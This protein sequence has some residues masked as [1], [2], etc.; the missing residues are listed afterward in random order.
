MEVFKGEELEEKLK[1]LK[2]WKLN[3]SSGEIFCQFKF[4]D[5]S[6]A[7]AFVN[8]V[9]AMAEEAGH[10]PDITINYNRV[11]LS[12]I[13]HDAGGITGKDFDLAR[14]VNLVASS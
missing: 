6:E 3:L 1:G 8:K 14:Q 9:G 2:G 7:L 11:F 13:T 10:H 5:F 12:V 4:K